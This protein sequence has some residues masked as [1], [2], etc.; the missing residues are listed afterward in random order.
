MLRIAHYADVAQLVERRLPKPLDRTRRGATRG[1]H[2]LE[3]GCI[4]ATR[5]GD[6]TAMLGPGRARFG[7]DLG[8]GAE[9]IP[10]AFRSARRHKDGYRLWARH[11]ARVA[12]LRCPPTKRP[13]WANKPYCWP[14]TQRPHTNADTDRDRSAA[15]LLASMQGCTRAVESYLV[16]LARA[17]GLGLLEFLV[18]VRA[19]EPEGV[20]A[21][22]AGLAF[23]MSTG[24]MTGIADRLEKD[25]LL[26]RHPHPTDRRI[27]LLKA[28][29]KGCQTVERAGGPLL[30]ALG[31]L[32]DVLEAEQRAALGAFLDQA[33]AL[34]S[35]HARAARAAPG[36]RVILRD[37]GA[38]RSR[39]RNQ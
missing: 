25:G 2:S 22:D 20:T 3:T 18:L 11:G 13:I 10:C 19:A 21:R 38:R 24:T 31:Q 28:S 4:L 6:P 1:Q 8:H 35:E 5:L 29:A 12:L 37:P 34:V 39:P 36:G 9:A 27:L 26:R 30:T 17:T 33:T 15:E 16:A 32:V 23:G 14:I 7:P